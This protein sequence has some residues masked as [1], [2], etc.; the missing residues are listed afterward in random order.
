MNPLLEPSANTDNHLIAGTLE[1]NCQGNLTAHFELY[2]RVNHLEGCIV[3][4]GVDSQHFFIS[5][6]FLRSM[7]SPK[8]VI[9]FEKHCKS[10]YYDC[11]LLPFGSLGYKTKIVDI[12]TSLIKLNLWQKGISVENEFIPNYI[13]DAIPEYLIENPELK[14]SF[15]TINLDDYEAAL[16]SLQ[17]FYPR[18]VQGGI[19][20]LDNFYKNEDDFSAVCDYFSHENIELN[21]FFEGKGPHFIIK[22]N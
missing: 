19:L 22:Q 7:M 9:A 16:T 21:S 10:M 14:I 2:K 17:F 15:L 3:N 20:V 13:A 1:K 5:F 4:C 18:L 11:S 6:A 12:N 8:K